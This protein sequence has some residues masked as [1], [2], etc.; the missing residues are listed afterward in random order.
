MQ[1]AVMLG[2]NARMSGVKVCNSGV[3]VCA[4]GLKVRLAACTSLSVLSQPSS[5]FLSE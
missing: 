5:T 2:V 1:Y 3:K 4:S